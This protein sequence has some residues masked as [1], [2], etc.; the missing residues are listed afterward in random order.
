MPI[1]PA[2]MP[3]P[4]LYPA[5]TLAANL[6]AG[7]APR[8]DHQRWNEFQPHFFFNM[9][10]R[11]AMHQFHPDIPASYVWGYN[12]IVPGATIIAYYDHPIIVRFRNDLP[13]NHTGFGINEI[14]T[15]L[16]NGHTGRGDGFAQDY[17]GRA[18]GPSPR[19]CWRL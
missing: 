15:H 4:F 3:S 14:T 5:P 12:G 13:A 9:S 8:A 2:A 18:V 6:G 1:P 11:P 10:A 17:C 7:E 19:T 16:H